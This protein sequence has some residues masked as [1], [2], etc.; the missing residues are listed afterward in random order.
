MEPFV[1]TMTKETKGTFVY[2]TDDPFAPASSIY[3]KKTAFG[4]GQPVPQTI[5]LTITPGK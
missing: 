3:V 5:T 2:G 1:L 4:K